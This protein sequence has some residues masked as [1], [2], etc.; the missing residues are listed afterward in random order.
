MQQI[1]SYSV[2]PSKGTNNKYCSTYCKKKK[3]ECVK[4]HSGVKFRITGT[5]IL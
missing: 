3:E 2:R 1:E 4:T 5:K